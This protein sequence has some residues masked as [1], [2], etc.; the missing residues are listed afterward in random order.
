MPPN[1]RCELVEQLRRCSR[2]RTSRGRRGHRGAP[3][4]GQI[5]TRQDG[6]LARGWRDLGAT[7][8]DLNTMGAGFTNV[9]QHLDA[10]RNAKATIEKIS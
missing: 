5:A 6:V 4:L 10:L 3:G 1:E 7:Y 9:G 8:L 2:C